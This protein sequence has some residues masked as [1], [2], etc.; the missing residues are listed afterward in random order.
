L[1]TYRSKSYRFEEFL[2][3]WYDKLQNSKQATTVTIRLLQEIERYKVILPVLK[4][5][6]GDIF[7][8]QHWTE[9]YGIL[10]M[11]QKAV[12]KLIFEDFLHVKERLI[13]AEDALKELNNRAAGE[14]VIREALKEL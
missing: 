10:G 13:T 1:I 9:M 3:Q 6:R 8:E 11:P 2:G 5:V 7:S 12:D 4:Y 14:V